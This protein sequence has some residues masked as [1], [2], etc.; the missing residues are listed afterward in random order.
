M[1]PLSA[2]GLTG[3]LVSTVSIIT[4]SIHSMHDLQTRY[5]QTDLTLK[6]FIGQLSTLRAALN[7]ICEWIT[8]SLVTLPRHEQLVYDLTTSIEGCQV[9]LL[10]LDDRLA[11]FAKKDD[12][13]WNI[14]DKTRFLWAEHES[15][16]YLSQLNN[17]IS[18]LNLLLTALQW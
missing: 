9:L 18:A 13:S 12:E 16:Q 3:S 2:V 8:T 7:Q 1:D 17:H 4:K 15:N 14:L 11:S 5:R 10:I 6:L